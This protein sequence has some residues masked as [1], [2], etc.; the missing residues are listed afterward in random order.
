MLPFKERKPIMLHISAPHVYELRANYL[1]GTWRRFLL[2]NLV[3]QRFGVAL[4]LLKNYLEG[5]GSN[6]G[7]DTGYTHWGISW[8]LS[9]A[10]SKFQFSA[11]ISARPLPSKS[12]ISHQL[13][14]RS[15]IV[16]QLIT[17]AEVSLPWS[18][19]PETFP[20]PHCS[21]VVT[22]LLKVEARC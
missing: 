10:L 17:A 2:Q 21:D 1:H 6:F 19:Q 18:Q 16:V 8:F 22:Y 4:T 13:P 5:V 12:F 15:M 11:L 7:G 14:Y 9:V 20:C 3:S